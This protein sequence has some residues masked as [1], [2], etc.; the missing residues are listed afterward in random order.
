M[1][2]KY[3]LVVL[4]F[5]LF[6][7]MGAQALSVEEEVSIGRQAA[8]RFE[9]QYGLVRDQAMQARLDR[10]GQQLLAN[11]ERQNL[12]WRFRV[13]DIEQFNAAAFPGGF[14]YATRGL[15]N[16]LSDEELAFVVG[17][18]IAH[19][20]ERHSVEQIE[21]A[22]LRRLGLI[23]IAAGATGGDVNR[24]VGTLVQLTDSVIG[25]QRSQSDES[26][27]DRV[28]MRLMAQAGIDPAF[29]L[30]SLRELATASGG[31][32]PGFL[33]TLLGSH[34]LPQDRIN[35]GADLI[36]SVPFRP[37]ARQPV[38]RT[39]D[40]EDR[41]FADATAALEQSLTLQGQNPSSLLSRQAE[42]FALY[43]QAPIPDTTTVRV[44]ESR[45]QGLTALE[46]ELLSKPEFQ[47]SGQSFGA[48]VVDAGNGQVEAVVILQGGR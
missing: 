14:I 3:S 7:P 43:N 12:P 18:E 24:T 10:I 5:C 39:D 32:T 36:T 17:H 4:L 16:G 9:N 1:K 44:V 26:E 40:Q 45:D 20:D 41:L 19:V 37:Q 46:N 33:N 30:A 25:S 2:I 29:A 21:S 38:Q 31:G 13:I 48:A 23:A 42:R 22:Q 35:Q 34:P 8:Q 28:G 47:K 15:M 11:A 27:A 6:L